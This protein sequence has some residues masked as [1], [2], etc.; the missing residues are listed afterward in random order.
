MRRVCFDHLSGTPAEPA[1]VEAMRPWFSEK[2]GGTGALHSGGVEARAAL[3]D[4]R[5]KVARFINAASPEEIIFTSSGT[6]AINLAIKGCALADRKR[7]NNI[8]F[9]AIDHPA[10]TETIAHL[11]T[12]GFNSLRIGVSSDGLID[13]T[14]I[15]AFTNEKVILV[16][17]HAGNHDV[18]TIQDLPGIAEAADKLGAA[19]FVDATYAASWTPIDVQALNASYLAIAPHRFGGPKGVGILYKQRRARLSPMIHGGAQELGWRAGTENIP[20]IIGAGVACELAM[21]EMASRVS[22]VGKLQAQMWDGISSL[23]NDVRL[24]G[25][26]PGPKRLPNSLNSSLKGAEGEGLALALD[27]KGFAVTSGQACT[28]K[29]A[30]TPATLAAMGVPDDYGPGTIIVSFGKENTADEVRRFLEVFPAIVEK[31][32]A[33]A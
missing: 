15:A 13:A 4:A 24:N 8:V 10:V 29:A 16:C 3:D 19:F 2:F 31:I 5:E 28:T 21:K 11:Q 33:L 6:E 14:Q 18:G 12:E 25:P 7:G 23:V 20:G 27:M 22:H 30:K 32:R 17:A 9:S 26:L 1:V